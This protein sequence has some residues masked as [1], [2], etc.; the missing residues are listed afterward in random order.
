MTAIF[1]PINNI[2]YDLT[3][4]RG[5]LAEVNAFNLNALM[6]HK[7]GKER[8]IITAVKKALGE[9]VTERVRIYHLCVN[10]VL[11]RKLLQFAR[12]A[13]CGDTLSSLIEEDETAVM[14]LFRKPRKGF[15]LQG[16]RNVDA[17]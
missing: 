8:Y 6:S 12:N 9:A 17:A 1:L 4:F 5:G 15:F 7:I 3:L 10:A 16:L 11:L 14:L 13:P 2:V